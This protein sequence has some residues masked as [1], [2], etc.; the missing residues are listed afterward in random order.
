[1]GFPKGAIAA[2]LVKGGVKTLPAK[3][4]CLVDFYSVPCLTDFIGI[5]YALIGEI[6]VKAK[7]RPGLGMI[8]TAP[9]LDEPRRA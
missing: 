6:S 1:M 7:T 3:W 5:A 8:A 4:L 2:P 9:P